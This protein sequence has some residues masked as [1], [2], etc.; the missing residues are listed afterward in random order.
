VSYLLDT[1]TVIARLNGDMRVMAR[2][3]AIPPEDVLLC[4]P[5]VA[6]LVFGAYLSARRASN[7]ERVERLAAALGVVP[8]DHAA[9]HRFGELKA[10]LRSRG[11]IKTDFDLAIASLALQRSATLVSHDQALLD[12]AIPALPTEDWLA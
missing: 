2:L 12:G 8:F 9:A 11:I 7:L 3:A 4:A 10:A 6:E 5:V 1:N